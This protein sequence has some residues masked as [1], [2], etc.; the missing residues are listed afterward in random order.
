MSF[1]KGIVFYKVSQPLYEKYKELDSPIIRCAAKR[2]RI[3]DG[4]D[5]LNLEFLQEDGTDEQ[6]FSFSLPFTQKNV[7]EHLAELFEQ[8]SLEL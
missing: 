4:D 2:V 5:L 3:I 6:S 7:E 8:F 1:K